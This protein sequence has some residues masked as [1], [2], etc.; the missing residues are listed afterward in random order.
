MRI[1]FHQS[2][3]LVILL[4][5]LFTPLQAAEPEAAD[6]RILID[7]SGSM[8]QNDPKNLRRSALRLIVGLMPNDNRAGVWTFAQ[9]TN[10][11]VPLGVINDSWKSKARE[12]SDKISSPGQFTNIEDVM[13][14][15]TADW[16]GPNN[17]YRRNLILLTDGMVDIS[18][19]SKLNDA[20]RKRIL[21]ELGPRIQQQGGKIH[22]IALSDR[23]DHELM[24]S[25]SEMTGGWYE[26][27][28]SADELQRVFLR[29]FEKVGKPDAVPL[30][31]NKFK[32]DNSIDEATLLVFSK[33]DA[34]VTKI[35]TPGGEIFDAQKTP[36]N[37]SWH[38]DEGYDLI[39]INKPAAGEWTIQADMDP[40]NRVM[41]VTN[42]KMKTSDIPNRLALGE[43]IPVY[44][45]FSDQGKVITKQQF[46]D[47]VN[48]SAAQFYRGV[49]GEPQ[50][51]RDDGHEPD[52][53]AG[54]G[55]FSLRLG[56]GLDKGKVEL[57]I[58]ADGRTFVRERRQ[59]TQIVEPV[60]L[61]VVDLASSDKAVLKLQ[62]DPEVVNTAELASD[63]WLE[64]VSGK[65]T[66]LEFG[67]L[68]N[69]VM[70]AEVDKTVIEGQ[71]FAVV[72]VSGKTL[73]GNDFAYQP[74]T[75]EIEGLA[76][77]VVQKPEPPKP[78][79]VVAAEPEPEPQAE[80]EAEK[81]KPKKEKK[82]KEETDW[83]M[84]GLAIGGGNLLLILIGVGVWWFMRSSPEEEDLNLFDEDELADAGKPA[85]DKSAES[86][87][88][89][90]KKAQPAAD[91]DETVAAD[92]AD[93]TAIDISAE[94][95]K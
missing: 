84:I 63:A 7:I 51:L 69:A 92:E 77:P 71:H 18:K 78:E 5:F 23:A 9:Y 94:A 29:M 45:H 46:L 65:R 42:L 16:D 6:T 66:K 1:V 80:A 57:I 17:A 62:F 27:V 38:R 95:E 91:A 93:E 90:K 37:V 28:N 72:N 25:L 64:D 53:Q 58:S 88:D 67:S 39:T 68:Q 3:M 19:S 22:T 31:G 20:S 59:A 55:K 52:E 79:K 83:T 36:K 12:V 8:K 14:R 89:S 44:A 21:E 43:A 56:E 41:V 73:S 2:W 48:V 30:V 86:G 35:M 40:D 76:K 75:V 24:K 26:Q 85:A 11:L 49:E 47:V 50:P 32:L 4:A 34:D 81:P 15:A 10:M 54:D 61:E 13:Q 74:D 60:T 82:K 87:D 70:Q 33:P